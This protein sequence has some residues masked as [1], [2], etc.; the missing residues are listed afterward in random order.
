VE[1]AARRG[2]KHLRFAVS[3]GGVDILRAFMS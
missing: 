2:G 3:D 1:L